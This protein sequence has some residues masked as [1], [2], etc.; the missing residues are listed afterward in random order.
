M[1]YPAS[2]SY[3]SP[4]ATGGE[5]DDSGYQQEA[6]R[7]DAINDASWGVLNAASM[8]TPF[9]WNRRAASEA[10]HEAAYIL[11]SSRNV[12]ENRIVD[13]LKATGTKTPAEYEAI[14]AQHR[15]MLDRALNVVFEAKPGAVGTTNMIK[16]PA[17]L[18]ALTAKPTGSRVLDQINTVATS[19]YAGFAPTVFGGGMELGRMAAEYIR[20]QREHS[21]L[22]REQRNADKATRQ[23]RAYSPMT[24]DPKV[25]E[26]NSGGGIGG[27]QNQSL[28]RALDLARSIA[29]QYPTQ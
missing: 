21:K 23:M 20:D 14:Y 16:G 4:Y 12:V 24:Y 7:K 2:Y 19:P 18:Q 13:L 28:S 9:G 1:T 5:V 27:A 17:L 25:P 3:I 10:A 11:P 26:F 8:L 22:S 15:P 29:Q 6:I